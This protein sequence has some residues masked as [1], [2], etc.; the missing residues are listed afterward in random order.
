MKPGVNGPELHKNGIS[1]VMFC[2]LVPQHGKVL[3]QDLGL[4]FDLLMLLTL[5]YPDHSTEKHGSP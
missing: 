2:L 4:L 3:E 5:L 1:T